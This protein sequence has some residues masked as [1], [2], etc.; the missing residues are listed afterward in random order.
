[1]ITIVRIDH[2]GA[3]SQRGFKKSIHGRHTRRECDG[4]DT[5]LE[6]R[7]FFLEGS[8]VGI[9]RTRVATYLFVRFPF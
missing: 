7:E 9:S 2:V 1:M 5:M 6:Q 3:G 4:I 8:T